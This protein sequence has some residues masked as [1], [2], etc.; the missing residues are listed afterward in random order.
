MDLNELNGTVNPNNQEMIRTLT[1]P[2]NVRLKTNMY[3]DTS[4]TSICIREILDN[5]TDEATSCPSCN[6]I[7]CDNMNYGPGMNMVADNGRGIPIYLSPDQVDRVQAEIGVST[8]HAGS[9]FLNINNLVGTH[10]VGSAAVNA[11]STRFIVMSKIT[12]EN[13]DKSLPCVKTFY[14]SLGPRSR[15]EIFYYAYFECGILKSQGAARKKDLETMLGLPREL[16]FGM[17]TITLFEV[18][19]TIFPDPSTKIPIENLEYYLFIQEKFYRRKITISVND[20][21]LTSSGFTPYKFEFLKTIT[22]ADPSMNPYVSVYVTF[23]ADKSLSPKHS[24]GCV[25]G[26]VCNGGVHLSHL[27]S[28]YCEALK[29]EYKLNF[30]TLL[31][32]L[33]IRV[34]LLA[35]NLVY[36]SQ[37]KS[38]LK[39]ISKVKQSD[40][41][42]I[43]KEFQKI[44]RKNDDYWRPHVEKLNALEESYRSIGAV[45][46]AQKMIDASKGNSSFR[47]KGQNYV[48]G[49]S[50]ATSPD[51]WNCELFLCEGLSAAGGLK[52]GRKNSKYHAILPLRGKVMSSNGLDIDRALANKEIFTML[53]TI[54][55]GIDINF[56]GSKCATPEE[57]YAEIQKYARYGKIILAT[58]AD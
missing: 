9:K 48:E 54:G 36:D 41:S 13:Y 6:L 28:C 2:W 15:K 38:R 45:E 47:M 32:G 33:K 19:P 51:R 34:I 11:V 16:P 37:V 39:S 23:E 21:P 56:V 49:F 22:P 31:P 14:E 35:E 27:E 58:D 53:S 17:S 3:L 44:F 29:T 18:D 50:D 43:T 55:L 26:L 25:N 52:S 10:G 12:P 5:S 8:L 4:D 1:Y 57:T 46:K 7:I 24:E 30:K 42:E 20:A 40:F